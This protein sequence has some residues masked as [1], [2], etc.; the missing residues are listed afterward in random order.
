[1]FA[2]IRKL[3]AETTV[4]SFSVLCFLFNSNTS[5]E[6]RTVQPL[7]VPSSPAKVAIIKD[8]QQNVQQMVSD[9]V[10]AVLGSTGMAT[11]VKTGDVVV[12][13]PN[14]V[15]S[16][17]I[18]GAKSMTD[19]RVT[20]AVVNL[21]KAAG[22]STVIIAEGSALNN[23]SAMR[24]SAGYS[25]ANFPGCQFLDLNDVV[26][27]T[28]LTMHLVD[29]C[30]GDDKQVVAAYINA[31]VVIGVPIM[32]THQGNG[33]TGSLKNAFGIAPQPLVSSGGANKA[34]L[35]ADIRKNIVDYNLCRKPD[36]A[37]MDALTA[38]EANGPTKG[39]PVTMN[40][41][42]ASKDLVA[43]DA[44]ECS[45]MDVPPYDISSLVLASNVNLGVM[46]PDKITVV[47]ESIANVKRT[48][49]RAVSEQGYYCYRAT[50][51]VR[52]SAVPV[53]IDG[54]LAEWSDRNKIRANNIAQVIGDNTKWAGVSDCSFSAKFL[55]DSANLYMAVAVKD[56]E[57]NVNTRT[58][59][60]IL[61]GE[62]VELYVSTNIQFG[63]NQANAPDNRPN[64]YS[65]NYDYHIGFSHAPAPVNW[66]F[67]HNQSLANVTAISVDN[68][69]GYTMEV[70]IPWSNFNNFSLTRYRELGI[71]VAVS[72]ADHS[73][74][75]ID[76]K[77]AWEPNLAIDTDPT[78]MG[79]AYL[80]PLADDPATG[81]RDKFSLQ[82]KSQ[83][84]VAVGNAVWDPL[85]RSVKISYAIPEQATRGDVRLEIFNVNGKI[86]KT[87]T[88]NS[89]EKG[90]NSMSWDARD[91]QGRGVSQ[92]IYFCR[93]RC[94][95][96]DAHSNGQISSFV[97]PVMVYSY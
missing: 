24:D 1:M 84:T 39:T 35:H 17:T 37:V 70:K 12:I 20:L 59:A 63:N 85:H 80:T 82:R 19:Y 49:V 69:S 77:I 18:V 26:N 8:A 50:T 90:A 61:N 83:R 46:D 97:S 75:A 48:F 68:D 27:N 9:A 47:G 32:K 22:A 56:P 81:I 91:N 45:I 76:F 25:A 78:K 40:C 16:P 13:K 87:L 88:D 14:L 31:N 29:G 62:C 5:A 95:D 58:G 6:T 73:T 10:N 96:A 94:N 38:M 43:L 60:D 3:S 4:V 71:N 67:S 42:L 53:V 36:F 74:A 34:A 92:G 2:R 66:I 30:F 64:Y 89:R 79:L 15:A 7:P 28:T 21:V 86:I 65:T 33:V 11:L 52:K 72:D 51:A 93:L 41:V 23:T 44:V 57:K 54:S 55:Y